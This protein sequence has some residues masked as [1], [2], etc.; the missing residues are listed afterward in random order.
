MKKKAKKGAKPGAKPQTKLEPVASFFNFFSPPEVPDDGADMDE[1][2]MADL[3]D[4]LERDYEIGCAPAPP[5]LR[6]H[7]AARANP[8][9]SHCD[10]LSTRSSHQG[11]RTPGVAVAQKGG[12]FPGPRRPL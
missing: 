8:E 1:E 4:T 9:S 6:P 10:P 2:E 11:C 12:A 5:H 3:Q 7:P